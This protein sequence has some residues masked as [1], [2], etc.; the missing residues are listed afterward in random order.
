MKTYFWQRQWARH[1][2]LITLL[3]AFAAPAMAGATTSLRPAPLEPLF[4]VLN[5]NDMAHTTSLSL[6]QRSLAVKGQNAQGDKT[7]VAGQ[8]AL[9]TQEAVLGFE[10]GVRVGF[11]LG[12]GFNQRRDRTTGYAE[13]D[14]LDKS[15]TDPK[16][17]IASTQGIGPWRMSGLFSYSNATGEAEAI[18]TTEP[19]N[20][21]RGG[22]QWQLGA[23][24]GA[25]LPDYALKLSYLYTSI[26][27]RRV[28]LITDSDTYRSAP[29]EEHAIELAGTWYATAGLSLTLHLISHRDQSETYVFS[30]GFKQTYHSTQYVIPMATVGWHVTANGVV[31]ISAAT[32][33]YR[34]DA[35]PT[36]TLSGA[37]QEIGNSEVTASYSFVL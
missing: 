23:G 16:L 30:D 6:G 9:V 17:T 21:K 3:A 1:V 13:R 32:S 31:A 14:D 19:S 26:G 15:F 8:R 4:P 2:A 25:V 37:S 34:R 29:R 12:F 27:E 10:Q 20:F 18:T 35:R 33:R 28:R 7:A 5:P 22:H 36:A 24:W 11:A